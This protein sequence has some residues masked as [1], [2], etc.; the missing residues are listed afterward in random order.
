MFIEQVPVTQQT[1]GSSLSQANVLRREADQLQLWPGA[2]GRKAADRL[3]LLPGNHSSLNTFGKKSEL[4][5]KDY[6]V[7]INE[8]T[9]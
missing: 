2:L 6:L 7:G 1:I 3:W 5:D 9:L 8:K 4:K